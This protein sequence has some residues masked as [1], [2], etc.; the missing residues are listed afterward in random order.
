[1]EYCLAVK[2]CGI[3]TFW[4]VNTDDIKTACFRIMRG[5]WCLCIN[6]ENCIIALYIGDV[7]MW[8]C[9]YIHCKISETLHTKLVKVA[10]SEEGH[11]LGMRQDSSVIAKGK[12]SFIC[13]I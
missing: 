5:I 3:S 6:M 1:M 13:I 8:M 11:E 4:Y 7:S 9:V 12:F 2:E 10:T